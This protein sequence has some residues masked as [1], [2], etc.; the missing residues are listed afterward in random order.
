MSSC[1][2]TLPPE[3]HHSLH[4]IRQEMAV[5]EAS[6]ALPTLQ[7]K[8]DTSI[9]QAEDMQKA[10]ERS[11]DALQDAYVAVVQARGL[12]HSGGLPMAGAKPDVVQLL[13]APSPLS[14]QNRSALAWR[15][16]IHVDNLGVNRE[17]AR[18]SA[19]AEWQA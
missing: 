6:E 18:A 9:K 16:D 5:K 2:T 13:I 17:E 10:L 1:S 12:A 11:F 4:K 14:Q 3:I 19:H 8:L 7:E 15:P